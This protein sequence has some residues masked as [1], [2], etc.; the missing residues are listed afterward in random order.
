MPN[1]LARKDPKAYREWA[2]QWVFLQQKR[3]REMESG[4]QGLHHLDSSVVQKT[5]KRAVIEAGVTKAA[6]SCHAPAGA[7]PGHPDDPGVAGPRDVSTTW[8]QASA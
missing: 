4:T 3:W 2:W 7:G 8:P 5:V 6:R 1:S